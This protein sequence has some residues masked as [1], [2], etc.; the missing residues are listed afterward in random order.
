MVRCSELVLHI[1]QTKVVIVLKKINK[2]L[3]KQPQKFISKYLKFIF[4]YFYLK[5]FE[6]FSQVF[7]I[8]ENFSQIFYLVKYLKILENV[9]QVFYLKKKYRKYRYLKKISSN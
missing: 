4:K 6:I 8:L 7:E 9:A 1:F 2:N 3:A 5:I